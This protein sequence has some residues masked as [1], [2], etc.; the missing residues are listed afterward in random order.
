MTARR[1]HFV[2]QCYL[3]GFVRHRNKPKLFVVDGRE[4]RSFHTAPANVA[5]ERDFHTI[6]IEGFPP[7]ALEN[8]F[9]SFEADVRTTVSTMRLKGADPFQT[10]LATIGP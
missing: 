7:D 8:S 4:R 3:K 2:P 10:I 6:E 9:A 5:A 1:H